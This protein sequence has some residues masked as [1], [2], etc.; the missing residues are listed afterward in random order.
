MRPQDGCEDGRMVAVSEPVQ[1][2][3]GEA[4]VAGRFTVWGSRWSSLG[5]CAGTP[6]KA[7]RSAGLAVHYPCTD[8]L[9][10]RQVAARVIP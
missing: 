10:G 3:D 4:N 5:L 1:A 8:K 6:Y 2:F 9:A 7:S